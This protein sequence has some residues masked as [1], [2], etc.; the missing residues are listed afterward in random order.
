MKQKTLIP[1]DPGV[2]QALQKESKKSGKSKLPG[3]L[4]KHR[5]RLAKNHP[6]EFFDLLKR[7]THDVCRRCEKQITE[8]HFKYLIRYKPVETLLFPQERIKDEHIA[9]LVKKIGWLVFV[10]LP[11]RLTDDQVVEILQ[12]LEKP[13]N[14]PGNILDL[15]IHVTTQAKRI[16]ENMDR[17][18]PELQKEL[19]EKIASKI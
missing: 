13:G 6:K 4:R 17:F 5:R 2:L 14:K 11:Q 12:S 3:L 15:S 9:A 19:K 1:L 8:E 18:S 10:S 7:K 16:L